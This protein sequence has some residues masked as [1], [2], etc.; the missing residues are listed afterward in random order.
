MRPIA[1]RSLAAISLVLTLL[2]AA[3]RPHYGGTLRVQIQDALPSLEPGEPNRDRI[4][5][6][7]AETL[8]EL[9]DRGAPRL[10]LVTYLQHDADAKRWSF[11]LRPRV[12]FHDGSTLNATVAAAALSAVMKNIMVTASGSSLI[13]ESPTPRPDLLEELANPRY[14]IFKRTPEI[15][16]V[17]T[18][19]FRLN[20]WQPG[21]PVMLTAF[22]EHWAG[23]PYLDAI[24]FDTR[25][26]AIPDIVELPVNAS[27][28]TL[29]EKLHIEAS[30]PSELI[31]LI[32]PVG[33]PPQAREALTLAMDRTS[34]VNVLLQ[35]RGEPTAALLPN[36]LSG[37]AFLFPKEFDPNRARQ[38][39]T[40]IRQP[41]SLG[42]P[43][44]DLVARS[45][46]DRIA[47]NARDV[48]I[49]LQSAAGP[50]QARL[51]RLPIV[52]TDA[53]QA[54]A[55]IAAALGGAEPTNNL[56]ESERALID[57]N[58]IV[59]I[60]HVLRIYGV[61]TRVRNLEIAKTGAWH[62]ENAWISLP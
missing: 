39:A 3:T 49:T 6:L 10:K 57:A 25:H 19:P 33:A 27:P 14:S 31:A 46:A 23:R 51:V 2:P 8:V 50:V 34:I 40:A 41:M 62:L 15:P 45:I 58:R 59:P 61:H 38:L 44:G 20:P 24:H 16:I 18:G 28:R 11:T 32:L 43:A 55:E 53:N 36:W 54:L 22:E 37:Y 47:L 60:A 5:S 29:S 52:S 1:L 26:S 35:R 12:V 56:L 48:G 7:I 17:G 42:Y 30:S 9:D 21:A 4:T 13:F